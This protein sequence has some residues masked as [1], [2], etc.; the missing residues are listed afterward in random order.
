MI[1]P[2]IILALVLYHFGTAYLI[3]FA[4]LSVLGMALFNRIE[5]INANQPDKPVTRH[6]RTFSDGGTFKKQ[7]IKAPQDAQPVVRDGGSFARAKK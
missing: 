3:A 4:L 7:S 5:S 1:L 2:G 6:P